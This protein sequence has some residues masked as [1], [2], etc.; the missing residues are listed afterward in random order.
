MAEIKKRWRAWLR[1]V[2]RDLGYLS[3]GFTVIYAVSGIAQNHIEEWGDV[4]YSAS[5]RVVALPAAIDPSVPDAAAIATVNRAVGLQA[6][7]ETFRAGDE[8][9]LSYAGGEK[10]TVI[11]TQ[12]T[13]QERERRFFIGV[14]NWLH[15]ARGKDAWKYISDVYALVLIYLSISGLLMIKGKLGLRWRGTAFMAAGIAVPVLYVALSDGPGAPEPDAATPPT[16][17][18]MPK[19]ITGSGSG[20]AGSGSASSGGSGSAA[21]AGAPVP[22]VGSGSAEDGGAVLTPLP[23]DDDA[24]TGGAVLVPLPP[25]G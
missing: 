11:G 19:Q 12:V 10:V 21:A 9:R 1:A 4:S 13:I 23:P 8:I 3:I 20:S 7:T 16:V 18:L 24:D 5:E 6:P 25:D 22:S 2:H 15:K 14:A 17:P